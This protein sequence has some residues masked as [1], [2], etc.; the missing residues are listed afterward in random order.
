MREAQIQGVKVN[1]EEV[2]GKLKRYVNDVVR[3]EVQEEG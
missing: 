3:R 2:L 1:V